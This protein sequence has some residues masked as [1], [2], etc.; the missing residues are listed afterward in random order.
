MIINAIENRRWFRSR[1]T[2][3]LITVLISSCQNELPSSM[4][5]LDW[6]MT[7]S[8]LSKRI[9]F[10]KLLLVLNEF[11][12]PEKCSRFNWIDPLSF[13][14]WNRLRIIT[15]NKAEVTEILETGS[16]R[17]ENFRKKQKPNASNRMHEWMK[18]WRNPKNKPDDWM[19]LTDA[20]VVFWIS[21]RWVSFFLH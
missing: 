20:F 12:I 21:N 6:A 16:I 9:N 11:K 14:E 17:C 1:L 8:I 10:L 4:P 5:E 18:M 19:A 7:D 15:R 13:V 2:M 3:I